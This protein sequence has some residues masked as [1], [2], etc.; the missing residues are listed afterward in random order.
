MRANQETR[1][2]GAVNST[3]FEAPDIE[4]GRAGVGRRGRE[5][6][7]AGQRVPYPEPNSRAS[8]NWARST[9]NRET[10]PAVSIR[11]E[12]HRLGLRFR[13]EH[14]IILPSASV[15]ADI[16]FTAARLAVFVDGC[17]WHCCPQHGRIPGRNSAYWEPKLENNV[18]RDRRVDLAL[19]QAGWRVVR[20][21]EHEPSH[22]AAI[23]IAT[24]LEAGKHE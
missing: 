12:L 9:S 18:A 5:L 4:C 20:V 16:V 3:R 22:D 2:A 17:F 8:S 1:S 11:S 23:S 14:R 15:R 13:K 7:V 19:G 24:L 6:S 21:W 10:K